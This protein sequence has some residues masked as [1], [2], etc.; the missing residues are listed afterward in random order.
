[1]MRAVQH[2]E[3]DGDN[4]KSRDDGQRQQREDDGQD[5]GRRDGMGMIALALA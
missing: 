1:M 2:C 3:N 4:S 5:K